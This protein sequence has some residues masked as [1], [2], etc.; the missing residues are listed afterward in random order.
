[1]KLL[2]LSAQDLRQVMPMA[3]TI[4]AMRAAFAEVANGS[5]IMPLRTPLQ[6]MDGVTL[7]MPAFLQESGSLAQKIVSVYPQNPRHRLPVINGLV[8]VLNPATGLPTA[9]MDGGTLTAMRTGAAAG[10]ATELLARPDS[11]TLTLFGAGGMAYDQVAAV[12][13]VRDISEVRIVS[14]NGES[15]E[16]LAARLR[17]EGL[18]ARSVRESAQA[19]S[20]ADIV[21]CVTPST[22]PLFHDRDIASGTH[23]NLSGA[24][25]PEMQ[26]APPETIARS[27][28]FIDQLEAALE[29]AG[30]LLKPL[31]AGL[32]AQSYF[33]NTLGDLILGRVKG[34]KSPDDITLFKSV[35]LAA[36]D[37]A[38]ASRALE[39][40]RQAGVGQTVEL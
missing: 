33:A 8:L 1:M 4:A 20:G 21:S 25:T 28:I 14:A 39:L 35:G 6:T 2:I 13:A 16:R 31:H 7:F 5:A 15:C 36:Q 26:E 10:L 3:E 18:D 40:A 37:A 27:L 23:I 19:L 32:I 38:A 34:R 30:D 12:R 29:E 11:R 17:A 24:F 22:Q 9:L